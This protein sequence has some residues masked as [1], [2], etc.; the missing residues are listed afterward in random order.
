MFRKS[1][2]PFT[3]TYRKGDSYINVSAMGVEVDVINIS[4]LPGNTITRSQFLA[5]VEDS[6]DYILSAYNMRDISMLARY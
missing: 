5:E 3:A 6:K 4:H 1:F 2:G